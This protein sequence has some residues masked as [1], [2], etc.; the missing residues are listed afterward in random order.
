MPRSAPSPKES[1]LSSTA[2]K[3]ESSSTSS[4]D[5]RRGMRGVPGLASPATALRCADSLAASRELGVP[6]PR[7]LLRPPPAAGVARDKTRLPPSVNTMRVVLRLERSRACSSGDCASS[8]SVSA[9]A[10]AARVEFEV[11][12]AVGAS[13]RRALFCACA[14]KSR[15]RGVIGS[16]EEEVVG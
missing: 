4:V 2:A 3:R 15:A 13:V 14:T 12:L 5:E 16:S 6:P 7:T 8:R 10:V 9:A 1:T 11:F